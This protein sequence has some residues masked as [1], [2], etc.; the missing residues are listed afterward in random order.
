MSGLIVHMDEVQE[1]V[2]PIPD[3]LTEESPCP[4]CGF[5]TLISGFGLAYGGYG[6]YISCE[7]CSQDDHGGLGTPCLPRL[8]QGSEGVQ[9]AAWS[10]PK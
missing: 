2:D 10:R 4:R 1:D 7:W 5:S 8:L 9:G 6:L 3:G